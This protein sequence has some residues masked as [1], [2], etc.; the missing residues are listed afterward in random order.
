LTFFIRF[1]C[2]PLEELEAA[3]GVAAASV[4]NQVADQ[5]IACLEELGEGCN[6]PS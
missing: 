5:V 6:G 3:V 1:S 4:A 2:L